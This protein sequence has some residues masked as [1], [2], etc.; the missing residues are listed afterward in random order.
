MRFGN[1]ITECTAQMFGMGVGYQITTVAR[2][3]IVFAH[4]GPG[5]AFDSLTMKDIMPWLPDRGAHTDP[6][7]HMTCRQAREAFAVAPMLISGWTCIANSL[8]PEVQA[9]LMISEPLH[10]LRTLERL[11]LSGVHNGNWRG[12]ANYT[13]IMTTTPPKPPQI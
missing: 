6:L 7:G 2:K 4:G 10:L 3:V 8:S 9:Q 1:A 11:R 13:T 12:C 5:D